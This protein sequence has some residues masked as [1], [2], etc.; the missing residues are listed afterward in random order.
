MRFTIAAFLL[1]VPGLLTFAQSKPKPKVPLRMPPDANPQYFPAG[2]FDKDPVVNEFLARWYA[3]ELRALREPSI[4]EGESPTT[5]ESAKVSEYRIT[6][7]PTWGNAISIRVQ[8]R[9]ELY[10][11]SARR[12]NGQAGY[13]PGELVESIDTILSPEDSKTLAILIQNLAFFQMPAIDNI[14]GMDGDEWIMEA[15]SQAKY[16]VIVR[17]CATSYNPAKRELAAFLTLCKFLV[18]VSTLSERPSNK[19]HKLI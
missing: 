17:W 4:Y 3:S 9:G 7:L 5:S 10:G 16:H 19:G 11:L 1:S 18:D 8:R 2:V 6:I 14:R 12:L 15:A 13:A